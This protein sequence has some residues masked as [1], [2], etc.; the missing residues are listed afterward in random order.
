MLFRPDGA[1]HSADAADS[2]PDDDD[3]G[4]AP[5]TDG[6]ADSATTGPT[7]GRQACGEQEWLGFTWDFFTLSIC[8]L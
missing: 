5:S 7:V 2:A 3:N 4:A 6:A 8:L 1:H